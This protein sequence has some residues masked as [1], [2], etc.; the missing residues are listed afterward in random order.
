MKRAGLLIVLVGI[1]ITVFTSFDF[2]T[3][4]KVADIG[5][6]EIRANKKYSVEWSPVLGLVTIVAGIGLYIYSVKRVSK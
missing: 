2:F 6:I 1:I 4:R 3:R 5:R